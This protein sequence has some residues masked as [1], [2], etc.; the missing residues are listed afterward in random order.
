M[1]DLTTKD[2]NE[3]HNSLRPNARRAKTAITLIWVILILDIFSFISAYLQYGLLYAPE[4]S[5]EAAEA[6]DLRQQIIGGV[7]LVCFVISAVT[8]IKWFRRAYYNLSQVDSYVS[9]SS[10]DVAISWFLPII[11]LFK[12][13]QIT[14]ELYQKTKQLLTENSIESSVKLSTSTVIA[15]WTLWVINSI[16]GQIA[17]RLARNTNTVDDLLLSTWLDMASS[18]I[19]IPLALLAIKVI[20]DYATVEPLLYEIQSEDLKIES[21]M[22]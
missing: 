22:T 1:N 8:F 5:E 10:N 9:Y 19:G 7:Y 12:P 20:R 16:L 14:K 17:L 21:A 13:Y 4:I 11:N 18:L 15:W 2:V 6:N 3:M